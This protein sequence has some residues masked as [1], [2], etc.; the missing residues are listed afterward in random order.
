MGFGRNKKMSDIRIIM[1]AYGIAG[2]CYDR[3]GVDGVIG[4]YLDK[5]SRKAVF[6]FSSVGIVMTDPTEPECTIVVS[7]YKEQLWPEYN[8]FISFI[9]EDHDIVNNVFEKFQNI[10][11]IEHP[12]RHSEENI[13]RKVFH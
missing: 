1:E 6:G 7:K 4:T 8:V 10:F 9:G 11:R 12:V 13:E 2:V 5:I 3:N